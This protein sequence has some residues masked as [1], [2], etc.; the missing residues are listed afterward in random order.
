MAILPEILYNNIGYY[1]VERKEYVPCCD[2]EGFFVLSCSFHS[3]IRSKANAQLKTTLFFPLHFPIHLFIRIL[4]L[5]LLLLNQ[6][7]SE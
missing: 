7:H 5:H 4:Q 2:D 1:S 6:L 3:I